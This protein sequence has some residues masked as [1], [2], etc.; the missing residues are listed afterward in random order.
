MENSQPFNRFRNLVFPEKVVLFMKGTPSF[1]TCGLSSGACL[2]LKKCNVKFEWVDL[3]Q[4]PELYAFL[5]EKNPSTS[6]PY[7][8]WGPKFIGSYDEITH[9]FENGQL[10]NMRT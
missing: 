1:P 6:P 9:M 5:R 2:M 3:L 10:R 4:D 7:L 8:Y